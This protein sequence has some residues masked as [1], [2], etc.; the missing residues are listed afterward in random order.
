MVCTK[1]KLSMLLLLTTGSLLQGGL[2]TPWNEKKLEE[3]AL[4]I[5]ISSGVMIGGMV[6]LYKL[7]TR[8]PSNE[9]LLIRARDL[10]RS[11]CDKYGAMELLSKPNAFVGCSEQDLA[12]LAFHRDTTSD[13]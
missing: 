2:C 5:G 4:I 9:Q 6:F 8:E 3:K 7:I 10:Y 11:L 1:S 12:T 13:C